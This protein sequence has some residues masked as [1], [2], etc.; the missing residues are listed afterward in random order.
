M[1]GKCRKK[2]NIY[3]NISTYGGENIKCMI[4]FIVCSSLALG[5]ANVAPKIQQIIY[6]VT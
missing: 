3:L 5:G 6:S 1:G 2:I 4:P